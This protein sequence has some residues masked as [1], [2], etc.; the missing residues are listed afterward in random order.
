MLVRLALAVALLSLM[1]RVDN[2]TDWVRW[3]WNTVQLSEFLLLG[4]HEGGVWCALVGGCGW[5]PAAAGV[6]P[7]D[8][9]M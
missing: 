5:Q 1:M 2:S 4:R 3:L 7:T 8:T 6:Q 9:R